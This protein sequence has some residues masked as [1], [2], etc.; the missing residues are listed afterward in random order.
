MGKHQEVMTLLHKGENF[1]EYSH[2]VSNEIESFYQIWL[3]S[4]KQHS[5]AHTD[6][7]L[8]NRIS[9]TGT[10]A[11]AN[12]AQT[13]C[14]F[15]VQFDT[16]KQVNKQSKF[17]RNVKRISQEVED[18]PI[19][20][21]DFATEL[22]ACD[23]ATD[24]P[25]LPRG[26]NFSGDAAEA[27]LAAR[28]GQIVQITREHEDKQWLY[29]SILVDAPGKPTTG[30]T[31]GWFPKSIAKVSNNEDM[32]KVAKAMGG[33]GAAEL[34]P[35]D[36]WTNHDAKSMEVQVVEVQ[37]GSPECN[38]VEASFLH[39]LK[40]HHHYHTIKVKKVERIQNPVLWQS[41][42]VKRNVINQSK[43]T[44]NKGDKTKKWLF[45][46]TSIDTGELPRRSVHGGCG[47]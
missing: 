47:G 25:R 21:D 30:E 31:S 41:F 19:V 42:A 2:A 7:D 36:T 11:K 26:I 16:M 12:N 45:H 28:P 18:A 10:E 34:A 22:R 46:G 40:T 44:N 15:E 38:T 14:K 1:V 5:Q 33:G 13:G 35:P 23:V 29:G 9:T 27:I 8:T 24:I 3:Q 6:V 4:G 37:K 20:T 39:T 32:K 17:G 43:A